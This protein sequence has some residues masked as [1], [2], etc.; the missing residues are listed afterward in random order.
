MVAQGTGQAQ[1]L[2]TTELPVTG[3]ELIE[4]DIT[5][6]SV[7][8]EE[9]FVAVVEPAAQPLTDAASLNFDASEASIDLAQARR[10]TRGRVGSSNFVGIGADFG[11]AEDRKSV[12]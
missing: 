5:A 7:P 4:L 2:D 3:A 10:R 9:S 8:A 11:Y 12:V 6:E 1:E